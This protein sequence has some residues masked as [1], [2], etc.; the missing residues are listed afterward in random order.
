MCH[1]KCHDF[2]RFLEQ[3]GHAQHLQRKHTVCMCMCVYVFV[4]KFV[5]VVNMFMC[6]LLSP[7]LRA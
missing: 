3:F 2:F 4:S 1:G 7:L 6:L 5:C